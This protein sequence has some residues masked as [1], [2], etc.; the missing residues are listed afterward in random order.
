MLDGRNCMKENFLYNFDGYTVDWHRWYFGGEDRR[1]PWP[2]AS[3][4]V[5]C[6]FGDKR[7][8]YRLGSGKA[9]GSNWVCFHLEREHTVSSQ[10][11]SR[12]SS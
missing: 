8:H 9:I 2:V 1:F 4:G 6:S 5:V 10:W 12:N 11:T 3:E 7:D